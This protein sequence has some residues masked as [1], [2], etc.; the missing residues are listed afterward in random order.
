MAVFI[1]IWMESVLPV[2]PVLDSSPDDHII[3]SLKSES[4]PNRLPNALMI[5]QMKGG[6]FWLYVLALAVERFEDN[7]GISPQNT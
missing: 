2:C 1:P 3:G 5:S 4:S 6:N 7:R